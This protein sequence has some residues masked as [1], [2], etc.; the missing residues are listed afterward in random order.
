MDKGL[1]KKR[2]KGRPR[3][4][5]DLGLAEKLGAIQCTYTEAAA[6][7]GIPSGTLKNR[8]DFTTAFKKGL[9]KGKM[10]IRRSQF[11]LAEKNAAMSIWLGKQYLGQKDKI[12]TEN[13]NKTDIQISGIEYIVPESK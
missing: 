1:P 5:I 3:V 2:G 8:E 13:T 12:E 9:E 11:K 10:S 6:V 7:M 4:D